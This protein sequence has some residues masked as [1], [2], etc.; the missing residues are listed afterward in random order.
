MGYTA[1]YKKRQPYGSRFQVIG[2]SKSRPTKSSAVKR[3]SDSIARDIT[4]ASSAPSPR[5]QMSLVLPETKYFDTGIN[6]AVV[7]SA[8]GWTGTEV[9]CD[10]YVN[11]SGTAAGYTDSA[12]IP[13]AIG[14]GYGQVNGN[15]YKLKKLRVR[16]QITRAPAS[17][18]AD[19]NVGTPVRLMLI[20]D[21]AP[22]GAQAQGE[23]IIQD[24]GE[25]E[26]IYAFKRIGESGGRFRI[27]KDEFFYL[28]NIVAGTD[29]ANTNSLGFS[30]AQFSFQYV[31]KTPIVVNV[32]SGSATPTIASLIT[33]NIFLL[34]Q[35][36]G[37]SVVVKGASRAYYVD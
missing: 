17:D 31:P 2:G 12:L 23:D 7:G 20:H 16:G 1:P 37:Q 26:S 4:K 9:A 32:K 6:I 11:S 33:A 3:I 13:S 27:L 19:M 35:P 29:A 5:A 14:S 22:N 15:R 21:T 18:Q 30:C 28:E 25:E 10:N 34:C 8:S 24:L 36:A